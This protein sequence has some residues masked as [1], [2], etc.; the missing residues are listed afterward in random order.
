MEKTMRRITKVVIPFLFTLGL[1]VPAARAN[2]TFADAYDDAPAAQVEHDRW[3]IPF[4]LAPDAMDDSDLSA[5]S[6]QRPDD[7]MSAST[8]ALAP[9]AQDDS[10]MSAR[11]VDPS[12]GNKG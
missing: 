7:A 10:G 8:Y 6:F 9:D 11:D 4:G 12:V 2:D 3:R 5:R 1:A